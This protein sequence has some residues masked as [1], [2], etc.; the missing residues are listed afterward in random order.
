M[1]LA[2]RPR[3]RQATPVVLPGHG[4]RHTRRDADDRPGPPPASDRLSHK[5]QAVRHTIQ[6]V[7]NQATNQYFKGTEAPFSPPSDRQAAARSKPGPR[8]APHPAWTLAA[9]PCLESQGHVQ[10]SNLT[11][12]HTPGPLTTPSRGDSDD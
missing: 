8:H 12:L 5:D 3:N 9:A 11:R 10:P 7:T 2:A 1:H 4:T 6:M